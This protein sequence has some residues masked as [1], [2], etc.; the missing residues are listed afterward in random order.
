[1]ECSLLKAAHTRKANALRL[2]KK[3]PT[4]CH[5]NFPTRTE[6]NLFIVTKMTVKTIYYIKVIT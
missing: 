1:M 4:P 2:I 3:N 5:H 6:S